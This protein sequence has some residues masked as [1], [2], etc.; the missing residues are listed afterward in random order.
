MSNSEQLNQNLMEEEAQYVR[1]CC[2]HR[3]ARPTRRGAVTI[4]EIGGSYF[5]QHEDS[6]ISLA[7]LARYRKVYIANNRYMYVV[8]IVS[9]SHTCNT[10]SWAAFCYSLLFSQ[11]HGSHLVCV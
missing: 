8:N 6:M 3:R 7:D 2:I 1:F 9:I 4:Q 11:N 5:I 10:R